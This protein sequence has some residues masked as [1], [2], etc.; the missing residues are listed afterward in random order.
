MTIHL[1]TSFDKFRSRRPSA[2]LGEM[3][4][5]DASHQYQTGYPDERRVM[6]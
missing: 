5:I 1:T 2:L 6:I 3:L 4:I